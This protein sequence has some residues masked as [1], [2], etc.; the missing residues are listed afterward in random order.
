MSDNKSRDMDGPSIDDLPPYEIHESKSTRQALLETLVTQRRNARKDRVDRAADLILEA[1]AEQVD[2]IGTVVVIPS[3]ADV[4]DTDLNSSAFTGVETEGILIAM[5]LQGDDNKTAFWKQQENVKELEV[6]L[7]SKLGIH[8]S[9]V[10]QACPS[11]AAVPVQRQG[12]SSSGQSTGGRFR[13]LFQST[14]DEAPKQG[15]IFN[16]GGGWSSTVPRNTTLG[17]AAVRVRSEEVS[18]RFHT[19]L[20]YDTKSIHAV[21]VEVKLEA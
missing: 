7:Y 8:D 20:L 6:E 1:V 15:T 13:S 21:V 18:V 10:R 3:D 19:G 14:Q 17:T 4:K 16:T 2:S 11:S 12:P 9:Y 5:R